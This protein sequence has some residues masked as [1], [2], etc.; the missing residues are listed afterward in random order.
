MKSYF[1]VILFAVSVLTSCGNLIETSSERLGSYNIN[2][3]NFYIS[4]SKVNGGATSQNVMQI[5]RV[6]K[7]STCE[8]LDNIPAVDSVVQFKFT[9]DSIFIIARGRYWA[10]DSRNDTIHCAVN[11]VWGSGRFMV[12]D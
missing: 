6:Y 2:N 12:K 4:I 9:T 1:L 8:V 3:P 10:K 5:R 7:D 11:K